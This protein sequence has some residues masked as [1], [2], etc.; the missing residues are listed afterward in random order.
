MKKVVIAILV[1]AV[2]LM[3]FA[4]CGT[5]DSGKEQQTGPTNNYAINSESNPVGEESDVID[6]NS[7]E[8]SATTPRKVVKP[9]SCIGGYVFD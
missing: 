4:G 8:Q 5:S 6:D 7:S 9:I 2:G 3:F 1:I